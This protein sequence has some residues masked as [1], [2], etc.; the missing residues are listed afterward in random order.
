MSD[1]SKLTNYLN[2]G[3]VSASTSAD[4]INNGMN[5]L[6]NSMSGFFK[7]TQ[8]SFSI[9]P[10]NTEQQANNR[11]DPVDGWFREA[12]DDKYCPKMVRTFLFYHI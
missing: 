3:G 6:K 7:K 12:D 10:G 4:S 9:N 5:N 2:E 8:S 11:D 1:Y